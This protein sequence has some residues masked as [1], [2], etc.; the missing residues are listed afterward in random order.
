MIQGIGNVDRVVLVVCGRTIKSFRYR[1]PHE[2]VLF[3]RRP[4]LFNHGSL[5]VRQNTGFLECAIQK[6]VDG[7]S[8]L[9]SKCIV[10]E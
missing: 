8:I 7:K 10:K 3:I 4:A 9:H 5:S 2:S 6:T 1:F